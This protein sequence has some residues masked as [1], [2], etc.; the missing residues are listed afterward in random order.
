MADQAPNKIRINS[1][2]GEIDLTFSHIISTPLG[3]YAVFA[4][5]DDDE[6]P[7]SALYKLTQP[8]EDECR[9]ALDV[10]ADASREAGGD[11]FAFWTD[12]EDGDIDG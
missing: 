9:M 2:K 4:E 6:D 8:S 10:W 3:N 7:V 1:F 11:G 5:C 12:E